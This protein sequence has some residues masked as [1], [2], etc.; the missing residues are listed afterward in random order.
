MRRLLNIRPRGGGLL[1]LG[2]APLLAALTLY[3]FASEARHALNAAD[4]ILP[5]L[6]AMGAA[7]FPARKAGLVHPVDILRGQA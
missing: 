4:K 5:T 1:L 7:Y 2:L 3:F 6:S